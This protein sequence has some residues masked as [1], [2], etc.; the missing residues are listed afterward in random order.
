MTPKARCNR[1]VRRSLDL[2]LGKEVIGFQVSQKNVN[3]GVGRDHALTVRELGVLQLI[4]DGKS[5]REIASDLGLSPNTV[6][7]HRGKIMRAVGVHNT[8]QLVVY[9]IREGLV[10]NLGSI[11]AIPQEVERAK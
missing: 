1:N 6:N 11:P 10:D 5:N 9:A 3:L 7:V 4:V 2:Q 8:A